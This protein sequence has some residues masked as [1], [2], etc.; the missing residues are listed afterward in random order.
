MI[1]MRKRTLSL[2]LSQIILLREWIPQN[3]KK[4]KIKKRSSDGVIPLQKKEDESSEH[5]I[6][7]NSLK[8]EEYNENSQ[9]NDFKGK[10]C[11]ENIIF[12]IAS[13]YGNEGRDNE[14]ID[15]EITTKAKKK[16]K[17]HK[18]ISKI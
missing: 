15:N 7:M 1:R 10:N 8:V 2:I 13:E 6:S 11:L 9:S 18:R 3:K 12:H 14:N 5:F 4:K 17:K 16:K